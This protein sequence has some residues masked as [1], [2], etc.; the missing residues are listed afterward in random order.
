MIMRLL[1]NLSIKNK[2]RAIIIVVSMV[3]LILSISISAVLDIMS[4]KERL[5]SNLDTFASLIAI[6][7][8]GAL[9]FGDPATSYENLAQLQVK[10]SIISAQIF[11]V[12]KNL[13][14]DYI[15]PGLKYSN[16][17]KKY[18]HFNSA[19]REHAGQDFNESDSM[20]EHQHFH[21][22]HVD[23]FK[24]I[25][26]SSQNKS[27]EFG[28]PELVGYLYL[29]TD[30]KEYHQ[31]LY[32]L[33]ATV[34]ILAISSLLFSFILASNLQK[35]ITGPVYG[36]LAT[37]RTVS[38]KRDY[39]I[40]EPEPDDREFASLVAGFNDMLSQIEARETTLKHYHS[41]LEEKV[42]VRTAELAE[43]RDQALAANK[44]KS[45]FLANMS[46]EIRTPM[47]AVLGYAQILKRDTELN[48][49]QYDT[50]QIIE[51]SG[52]HLLGLINDILDI[53]KIEAGAMELRAEKFQV[54]DLIHNIS[55]MFKM[56]C[57]EKKLTW[58]VENSLVDTPLLHADQG[59]LRQILINLLGNAVKFTE[60]GEIVLRISLTPEQH[61]RFDVIDTGQ[62][63][64]PAQQAL[65]FEPFQQEKAGYDKGGTG[66]GLAIT[67]R[68]VD[69]MNGRIEVSSEHNKGS[70][71]TAII[72]LPE[73]E[74]ES[75]IVVEQVK[76]QVSHLAQGY[77]VNALI[78]DD[79]QE[80]RD[81]LAKMLIDVGVSIREAENGQEAINQI[82]CEKPDIVFMD[83]RMPVM[84]GIM[85]IK[86]IVTQFADNDITCVAISASTLHHQSQ[87][88]LDA[89]FHAFISKPFRFE[90]VYDCLVEY[91]NVKF[92]YE[93]LKQLNDVIENELSVSDLCIPQE[94]YKSLYSAAELSEIT[95]MESLLETMANSDQHQ[96]RL[97]QIIQKF[98]SDYDIDSILEVLEDVGYE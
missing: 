43:A 36:L 90:M 76:G 24:K 29:R 74:D 3:I 91:L 26:F 83:I 65:I 66:L 92:D 68:Q 10:E 69:L 33:A 64:S 37:M 47:N 81:I 35:I 79:V 45:I 51:D 54:N 6:N 56:R 50:L 71:F 58:R 62:G 9:L 22:D 48:Q 73:S 2:L 38:R 88:I 75:D 46:H 12:S 14:S 21:A 55:L 61:Y 84:D 53:S 31:R 60:E 41:Q 44:A 98:L 59:K 15:H 25:V 86:H 4:Y 11:D 16:T 96:Q 85:A 52:T 39:T 7:A 40:R 30:L 8:A 42:K 77:S 94:I 72:P 57:D 49:S 67:K 17:N 34:I 18:A 95:E 80:N 20:K 93:E 28:E 97:A 5:R 89:G 87:N 32:I 82:Q 13:F 78:V 19:Y 1:H 27:E 70:C 23:T 63:I